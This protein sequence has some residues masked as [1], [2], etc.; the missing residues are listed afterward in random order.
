MFSYFQMQ[1]Y[2]KFSGK[3]SKIFYLSFLNLEKKK[4]FEWSLSVSQALNAETL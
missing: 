2:Y 3:E 1:K 4:N